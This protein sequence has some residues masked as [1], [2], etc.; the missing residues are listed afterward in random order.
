MSSPERSL[1]AISP[2]RRAGSAYNPEELNFEETWTQEE[3]ADKLSSMGMPVRAENLQPD[4][5]LPS[6][7]YRY[8]SQVTHDSGILT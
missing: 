1:G 3:L 4:L 5:A 8:R 6:R 7:Q 2:Q